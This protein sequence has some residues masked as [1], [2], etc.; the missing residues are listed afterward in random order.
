VSRV[1]GYPRIVK[2]P[3]IVGGEPTI[4]G[5]RVPVRSIVLLFEADGD[6]ESVCESLPTIT[7]EDVEAALTYYRDHRDE[8]E[9]YFVENGVEDWRDAG[10][11][12]LLR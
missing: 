3:R 7:R 9:R 4:A 2:D 6:Y 5:T 8:I 12:N 10:T 1:P 11:S